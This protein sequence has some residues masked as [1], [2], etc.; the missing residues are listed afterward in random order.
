MRFGWLDGSIY[1]VHRAQVADANTGYACDPVLVSVPAVEDG[2]LVYDVL[3]D[4]TFEWTESPAPPVDREPTPPPESPFDELIGKLTQT[5]DFALAIGLGLM[6]VG[7][8]IAP[9][10]WRVRRAA[11]R[12]A[13][14]PFTPSPA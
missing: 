8:C 4:L 13:S 9:I 6:V 7:A 11:V 1:L 5:G 10:G 3:A 14:G 12:L 2:L